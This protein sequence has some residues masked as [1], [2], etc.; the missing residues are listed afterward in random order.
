MIILKKI[1]EKNIWR[2]IIKYFISYIYLFIWR[3]ILN[4]KGSLLYFFWFK[5]RRDLFKLKNDFLIVKN[6]KELKELS[7]ILYKNC[8]KFDLDQLKEKMLNGTLLSNNQS[9]TGKKT[10][11][12]DLYDKLNLEIKKK[13]ID[14]ITSEKIIS[15]AAKHLGVFPILSRIKLNYNIINEHEKRGAMLW[16]RDGFGFK[17]FDIFLSITD[18]NHENGPLFISKEDNSM[19]VFY[20]FQ[21]E[22][23]LIPGEAGKID[24]SSITSKKLDENSESNI[25]PSGTALMID[26]YSTYHKGGNCKN[27]YR[28]VLR[29]SFQ[30]CDSLDLKNQGEKFIFFD[31]ID[32][33]DI[34]SGF[35]KHL[36]FFRSKI[37]SSKFLKNRLIK[38]YKILQYYQKI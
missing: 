23:N 17:S 33:K 3:F 20:R 9:N 2:V 38:F 10:Y 24:D 37:F 4:F 25:G 35:L 13:I 27:N 34:K 32:V 12:I 1:K 15:S 6:D 26:S 19:G 14:F 16:H 7:N 36:F 30:A 11:T 21:N 22:K 31:G 8:L 18:V 28:I 29:I 5:K